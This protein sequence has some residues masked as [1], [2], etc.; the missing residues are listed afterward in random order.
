M[1]AT[2]VTPDKAGQLVRC[3]YADG[4]NF[5]EGGEYIVAKYTPPYQTQGA[6]GFTFPAY[7]SVI[8]DTGLVATCHASRFEV[9]Q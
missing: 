8:D 3:L 5:K 2:K 6:G 9:I 1:N 4:Y 7:V